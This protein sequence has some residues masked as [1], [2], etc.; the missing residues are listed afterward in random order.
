MKE[1]ADTPEYAEAEPAIDV[2][3]NNFLSSMFNVYVMFG[4]EYYQVLRHI[5]LRSGEGVIKYYLYIKGQQQVLIINPTDPV[6]RT[7]KL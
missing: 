6:Y 3:G 2:F 5:P 7:S 1:F 4:G